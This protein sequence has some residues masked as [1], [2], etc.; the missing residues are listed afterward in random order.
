MIIRRLLLIPVGSI[1]ISLFLVMIISIEMTETFLE[2]SFYKEQFIRNDMYKFVE[3][4]L[5]SHVAR[6]ISRHQFTTSENSPSFSLG[7]LGLSE[8]D[9]AYSARTSVP[10]EWVKER[11]ELAID[12]FIPYATGQTDTFSVNIQL[13]DRVYIVIEEMIN[14][15]EV[16]EISIVSGG[17]ESALSDIL[18]NEL[19]VNERFL[20]NDDLK[21]FYSNLEHYVRISVTDEWVREQFINALYEAR[22]YI[23]NPQED[24]SIVVDLKP[25]ISVGFSLAREEIIRATSYVLMNSVL[26]EYDRYFA[27]GIFLE[28][29]LSISEIVDIPLRV[30]VSD[31]ELHGLLTDVFPKEWV[32]IQSA[33]LVDKIWL[34]LSGVS[35]EL[36]VVIP[37]GGRVH[38]LRD[39]ITQLLV[40]KLHKS[41]DNMHAC[42]DSSKGVLIDIDGTSVCVLPWMERNYIKSLYNQ[43]LANYISDSI[44][45]LVDGLIRNNSVS[46]SDLRLG[47]A[48]IQVL[49][50]DILEM[51]TSLD[52]VGLRQNVSGGW[53]LFDGEDLELGINAS[54]GEEWIP[55]LGSLRSA[56][57][58]GWVIDHSDTHD[59]LT[60]SLGHDGVGSLSVIRDQLRRSSQYNYLLV[61]SCLILLSLIGFL[62]GNRWNT[63]VYWSLGLLLLAGLVSII[64]L[65]RASEYVASIVLDL[66]TLWN[67]DGQIP[68]LFTTKLGDLFYGAANNF[69]SGIV[70]KS[71]LFISVAI[72]GMLFCL[73]WSQVVR[74]MRNRVGVG[75]SGIDE[76]SEL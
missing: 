34:Y 75:S 4:D 40:S 47:N 49:A 41:V 56:V 57:A 28:T 43:E 37:M 13:Q 70:A 58:N 26:S 61:F 8:S 72:L 62:G 22:S 32:D 16:A 35:D 1:F 23:L 6:E 67:T 64:V 54:L 19:R 27:D 21:D 48:E 30:L 66:S 69:V 11:V 36:D 63:R 15:A 42:S 50:A 31:Q 10:S 51:E 20:I 59:W 38:I 7:T 68:S 14:L 45:E 74:R 24:L 76:D 55:I 73:G 2:P 33:L 12:H 52:L 3:E 46:I 18:S 5:F 29:D 39:S 25:P 53:V 65:N 60:E 17:I 71:S 9:I 44:D